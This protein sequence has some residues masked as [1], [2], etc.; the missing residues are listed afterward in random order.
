MIR[1]IQNLVGDAGRP[2]WRRSQPTNSWHS[3][4]TLLTMRVT[5]F[6]AKQT[7]WGQTW[8]P[9]SDGNVS[10]SVGRDLQVLKDLRQGLLQLR[11]RLFLGTLDGEDLVTTIRFASAPRTIGDQI[12]FGQPRARVPKHVTIEAWHGLLDAIEPP[13]GKPVLVGREGEKQVQPKVL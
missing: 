4:D 13:A 10:I 5:F 9:A 8:H 1:L 11:C 2:A 3:G 6:A 12:Q 7:L